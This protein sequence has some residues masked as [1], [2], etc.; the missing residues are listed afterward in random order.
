MWSIREA[1][2]R[3][4]WEYMSVSM[5]AFYRGEFKKAL[6]IFQSWWM[7]YFFNHCRE[8]TNQI[9]TGRNSQGRLLTPRAR[10][11]TFKGMGSLIA[12]SKALKTVF[13]ITMLKYM[14]MPAPGYLPPI[15]EFVIGVIQLFAADDDKE[16]KAAISRIKYTAKFWIPF[17][18][19]W[20]DMNR[21]LSGEYDIADY[22]FYRE[23]KKS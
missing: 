17:S 2:R 8:C 4:Q 16:R 18:A 9:F 22:I 19:A 14:F 3:T 21:L 6:G 12:I 13:G 11:R 20:R 5:P 10:L 1:V 7:N 15:P 23:K